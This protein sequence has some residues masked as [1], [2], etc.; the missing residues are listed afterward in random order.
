MSNTSFQHTSYWTQGVT[1]DQWIV[2]A[3]IW[4]YAWCFSGWH[5]D[6]RSGHHCESWVC[7]GN[8][9]LPGR[10]G[11]GGD[12]GFPLFSPEWDHQWYWHRVSPHE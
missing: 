9:D 3:T 12:A 7:R 6:L 8:P 4:C 10:L 1:S 11:Y 2:S 5:H